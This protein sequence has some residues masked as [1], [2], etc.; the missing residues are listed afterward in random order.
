V[1]LDTPGRLCSTDRWCWLNPLPQGNELEKVWVRTP[2]DVW[3]VGWGGTVIRFD[4]TA[5]QLVPSGTKEYLTGVWGTSANDVWVTGANGTLRHWTG[6]GW[7]AVDTGNTLWLQAVWGLAQNDVWAVGW[8]DETLHFDGT[9][10]TNVPGPS[11]STLDIL[12]SVWGSATNDVWAAGGAHGWVQHWDGH[13]WTQINPGV[14]GDAELHGVTGTGAGDVWVGGYDLIKHWNGSGWSTGWTSNRNGN[15]PTTAIFGVAASGPSEAWAVGRGEFSGASVL[16]FDGQSWA[17]F[18]GNLA[19]ELHGIGVLAPGQALAVGQS[20]ASQRITVG[21]PPV[22]LGSGTFDGLNA[23]WGSSASDIWAVGGYSYYPA[24]GGK[25]QHWDGQKWSGV[26]SA[27]GSQAMHAVWG[28]GPNDVWAAGEPGVVDAGLE[29]WDGQAWTSWNIS[30]NGTLYGL[31]GAASNDVWA[32]GKSGGLYH[33]DGAAWSAVNT[34]GFIYYDDL[35]DV[36]GTAR[37]DVW[38]VGGLDMDLITG[39][40]VNVAVHFDGTAWTQRPIGGEH[41]LHAVHGTAPDDVWAVGRAGFVAHWDGAKWTPVSV[42]TTSE[43]WSVRARS[44]TDVWI[45]GTYGLVLHWNGATWT[46]SATLAGDDILDLW[47][48]PGATADLYG[49]GPEGMILR[50]TGP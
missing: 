37:D 40:E 5:W 43:L 38:M 18:P 17:G 34:F 46:E 29:H 14:I 27:T 6:S 30:T 49:V 20:G 42:P 8:G 11:T 16:R 21:A 41:R 25:L 1:P 13:T 23:I 3:A 48:P 4:G 10:W 24:T 32:A 7:T 33:W 28:S 47:S 36:W 9:K 12:E 26:P 22:R 44:R 50:R 15:G 35:E 19:E 39:K 31:W 45:S 2:T